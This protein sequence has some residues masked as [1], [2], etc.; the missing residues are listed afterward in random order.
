MTCPYCGSNNL[1]KEFRCG[2]PPSFRSVAEGTHAC[3]DC[4][5]IWIRLGPH[6]SIHKTYEG[7]LAEVERKG[8]L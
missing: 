7:V 4:G 1:V 2:L 8:A 5:K 6:P 3:S